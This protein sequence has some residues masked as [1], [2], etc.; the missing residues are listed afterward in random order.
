MSGKINDIDI[1]C[2]GRWH[3]FPNAIS[4]SSYW[5]INLCSWR[6][7]SMQKEKAQ[8]LQMIY[9]CSRSLYYAPSPPP[10]N[11]RT[12][13]QIQIISFP[14]TLANCAY[15]AIFLQNDQIQLEN[16]PKTCSLVC[17]L[18]LSRMIFFAGS[19]PRCLQLQPCSREQCLIKMD[20][21]DS[22]SEGE[23][24]KFQGLLKII[25]FKK[26]CTLRAFCSS[27]SSTP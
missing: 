9:H 22:S 20:I 24:A 15:L 11:V 2:V 12:G 10:P 27:F 19:F 3:Q 7:C 14:L 4:F 18:E 6:L 8:N 23:Q 13:E 17:H 26:Q 1:Q 16:F 25:L 21:W 5:N